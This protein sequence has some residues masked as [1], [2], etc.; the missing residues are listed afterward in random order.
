[1]KIQSQ[2]SQEPQTNLRG[3]NPNADRPHKLTISIPEGLYA[4]LLIACIDPGT[5]IPKKGA[6]SKIVSISL[7][8]VF[9]GLA[10]GAPSIS[11]TPLQDYINGINGGLSLRKPIDNSGGE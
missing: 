9:K 6:M 4:R 3:R 2:E 10:A 1:M 8:E 7:D 5:G 11:L